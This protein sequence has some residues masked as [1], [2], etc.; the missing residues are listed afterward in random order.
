MKKKLKYFIGLILIYSI[1]MITSTDAKAAYLDKTSMTVPIIDKYK[2]MDIITLE[3]T[4]AKAAW[5]SSN[6]KIATVNQ[7]GWVYAKKAGTCTISAKV[8]GKTYKCNVTVRKLDPYLIAAYGYHAMRELSSDPNSVKINK[9]CIQQDKYG[10]RVVLDVSLRG[11]YTVTRR[12]ISLTPCQNNKLE[13][14]LNVYTRS[15]DYGIV[16]GS[17]D[18]DFNSTFNKNKKMTLNTSKV[19]TLYK[20]VKNKKVIIGR[21]LLNS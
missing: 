1:F 14:Y 16:W 8:S 3:G 9:A 7:K 19:K 21:F 15:K 10:V 11:L 20:Q 2:S 17:L 12:C 6:P 4:K 18:K 5:K 13:F